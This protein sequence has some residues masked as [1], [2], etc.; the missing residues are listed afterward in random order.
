MKLLAINAEPGRMPALIL[1]WFLFAAGIAHSLRHL[2]S[3]QRELL[4]PGLRE[5]ATFGDTVA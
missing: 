1:S 3:E 5:M 2:T 4:D